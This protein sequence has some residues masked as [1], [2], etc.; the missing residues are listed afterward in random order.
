LGDIR[1]TLDFSHTRG[2]LKEQVAREL[3]RFV[4]PAGRARAG[5]ERW[6]GAGKRLFVVT[7]SD[8]AFA[9]MVLNAVV[10]SDW[11]DLFALVVTGAG[12]P[13]FFAPPDAPVPDADRGGHARARLLEGGHA[14][15]VERLLGVAGSSVLYVGD[16]VRADVAPA[17]RHG[18]RTAHVASELAVV[19]DDSPWG[20][21]LEHRREPTWFAAA[22]RDHADL[23]CAR[24]DG[25]LDL[26]P[27]AETAN[28]ENFFARLR[29]EAP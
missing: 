15:N 22:I 25:L 23:V 1:R 6:A 20:G 28:G 14:S 11:D 9:T 27:R 18:W 19:R 21:A 10:G 24:V 4:T 7:N 17:R 5:L 26:D 8:R 16:N 13:G 3:E 29:G 12:K 2:T